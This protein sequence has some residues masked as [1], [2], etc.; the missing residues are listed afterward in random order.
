MLSSYKTK[1]QLNT[2]QLAFSWF[3]VFKVDMD[4]LSFFGVNLALFW[5][6][7][8]AK[9]A[10]WMPLGAPWARLGASWAHLGCV[11]ARLGSVLGR[12]TRDFE[13]SCR[14]LGRSGRDLIRNP[15]DGRKCSKTNGF[16][17]IF[18][19]CGVRKTIL[20]RILGYL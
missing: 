1:S 5:L 17:M 6:P 12:L 7:K 20:D 18:E 4:F 2:S 3:F 19:G 10:S 14:H 11:L 16:S 13:A 9:I 15:S 8:S